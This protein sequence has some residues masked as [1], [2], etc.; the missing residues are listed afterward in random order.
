MGK[1]LEQ[2]LLQGGHTEGPETYEKMLSVTGH[3][4]QIKTTVKC[5]FIP[6]RMAIINKSTNKCWPGCGKKGIRVHCWWKCRLVQTLWKT[7]WNFLRKL[8]LNCLL[9]QQFH[10][11]D[12]ILRTLKHQSKGTHA[13]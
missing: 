11:W 4:M 2:T 12:Y 1:R 3:Q 5:H 13:P 10:C 9:I 7:L 8:K 6:V